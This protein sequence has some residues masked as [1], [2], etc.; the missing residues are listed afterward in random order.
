[1]LG[2]LITPKGRYHNCCKG[3]WRHNITL[4]GDGAERGE[5]KRTLAGRPEQMLRAPLHLEE[6][7]GHLLRPHPQEQVYKNL[8]KIKT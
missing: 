1:M 2:S 7:Q 4:G 8:P 5:L 3:I 6:G